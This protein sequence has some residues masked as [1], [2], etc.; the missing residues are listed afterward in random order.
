MQLQFST[1]AITA[2]GTPV[3]SEV[4]DSVGEYAAALV[5]GL[6]GV[7]Y[8]VLKFFKLW[9][10]E[11]A[12]VSII[13]QLRKQVDLLMVQNTNLQEALNNVSKKLIEINGQ[14]SIARAENAQL[15]AA[16]ERL[17]PQLTKLIGETD[18]SAQPDP[19]AR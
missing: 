15:R 4:R 5:A 17:N 8:G 1:S 11:S 19:D 16:I 9:N 3:L 18:D 7:S 2:E 10:T 6:L 12:E 14:L 13:D